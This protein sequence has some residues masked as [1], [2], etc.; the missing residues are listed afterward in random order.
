[1]ANRAYLFVSDTEDH[2]AW[3]DARLSGRYP[4]DWYYDSR[5]CIPLAWFFFFRP[6]D[7]RLIPVKGWEEVGLVSDKRMASERFGRREHLLMTLVD[8]SVEWSRVIALRNDLDSI[9][10]RNLVLDPDEVLGGRS[11]DDAWHA[12]RIRT[13][14]RSL[15][16]QPPLDPT[17]LEL[18]DSYVGVRDRD[19]DWTLGQMVGYTYV[20]EGRT[21]GMTFG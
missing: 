1:M 4:E 7:V 18:L 8:A 9:T 20:R 19:A 14:L 12:D 13:I 17:V 16:T 3:F 2:D 21:H 11:E 6:E 5:W 15:D 10:G